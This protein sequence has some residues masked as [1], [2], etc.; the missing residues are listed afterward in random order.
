MVPTNTIVIITKFM[1]PVHRLPPYHQ[2]D[3]NVNAFDYRDS[4]DTHICIVWV[5]EKLYNN[6]SS[7]G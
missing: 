7:I 3:F 5:E 1:I 6:T 4:Y 2:R